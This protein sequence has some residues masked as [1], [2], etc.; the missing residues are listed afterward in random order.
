[1]SG[2]FD[3]FDIE[4]KLKRRTL[5]PWWI[6]LFC[7]IFMI[8][9]VVVFATI[10]QLFFDQRPTLSFYGLATETFYPFGMIVLYIVFFLNA[11]SGYLLWFEKDAAITVGKIVVFVGIALCVAS[12][13]IA[14]FNGSF[15]LRLEI[16]P[17]VLFYRKLSSIE[18]DWEY[19]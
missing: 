17:L 13:I 11:V 14:L 7:W 15:T 16:I 18:Y 5:L 6:K 1:M 2:N 19:Q 10:F 3:E 8:F 9:G 12:F 4:L